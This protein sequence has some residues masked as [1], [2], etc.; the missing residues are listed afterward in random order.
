MTTA[1][2][3]L[4]MTTPNV[5]DTEVIVICYIYIDRWSYDASDGL[6]PLWPMWCV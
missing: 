3:T 4:K 6:I 1:A 5:M 2:T